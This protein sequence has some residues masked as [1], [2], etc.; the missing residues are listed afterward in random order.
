MPLFSLIVPTLNGEATLDACLASVKGQTMQDFELVLVDGGS[1]DRTVEMARTLEPVLGDRLIL[2]AGSDGG[3]YDA[4][5]RGVGLARGDWLLFL[6]ADDRL[7]EDETLARVAAFIRRSG[8]SDLVYGDVVMR[9]TSKRY[10]GQ[11]DLDRLLFTENICHQAVFYRRDLF[12]RLGLY[13]LRYRIWADWDFNIRCFQHPALTARHMD[14]VVADYNDGGGL[15][16]KEDPELRKRLPAFII[17]D[18]KQTFCAK[19]GEFF[20][21]LFSRRSGSRK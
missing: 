10:G 13:N 12:A 5:N 9:S 18:S 6:G 15:S 2:H 1:S 16:Q 17:A 4:M 21:G 20:R 7:H 3:V 14:L 8:D 11:F 19:L